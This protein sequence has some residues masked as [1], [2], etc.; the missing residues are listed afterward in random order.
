VVSA[1]DST[2]VNLCFLDPQ[3]KPITQ[4]RILQ[5]L[6]AH[7]LVDKIRTNGPKHIIFI[8]DPVVYD[9]FLIELTLN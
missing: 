6:S 1:T 8:R 9:H 7:K 5:R 2:A 3:K 4:K